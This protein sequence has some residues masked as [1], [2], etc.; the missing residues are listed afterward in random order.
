MLLELSTHWVKRRVLTVPKDATLCEPFACFAPRLLLSPTP[1]VI[2][3]HSIFIH[4][5]HSIAPQ[6][7]RFETVYL[8]PSHFDTTPND[9]DPAPS[10]HLLLSSCC[11][12]TLISQAPLKTATGNT[13]S[14]HQQI[15]FSSHHRCFYTRPLPG[16]FHVNCRTQLPWGGT[17]SEQRWLIDLNEAFVT[18]CFL[19]SLLPCLL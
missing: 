10:L 11:F 16:F 1:H 7:C 15:R 14:C 3:P 18:S 17:A 6:P 12:H 9:L 8:S 2:A 5:H 4:S 13:P 19:V